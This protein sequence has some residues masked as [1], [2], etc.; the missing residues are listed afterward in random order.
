MDTKYISFKREGRNFTEIVIF[1]ETIK[2]SEMKTKMGD[3]QIVGAGFIRFSI[4]KNE[5]EEDVVKISCYGRSES[6]EVSVHE[7]DSEMAYILFTSKE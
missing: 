7:D 3:I 1:P 2:H 4:S 6:L 5:Y